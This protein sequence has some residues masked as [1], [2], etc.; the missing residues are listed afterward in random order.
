MDGLT[1][2]EF[3]VAARWAVL[4]TDNGTSQTVPI[5]LGDGRKLLAQVIDLA[6][7]ERFQGL[8]FSVQPAEVAGRLALIAYQI[9]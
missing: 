3:Q 1:D 2:Q 7:M 5:A 9:L 6:S 8:G 4:F